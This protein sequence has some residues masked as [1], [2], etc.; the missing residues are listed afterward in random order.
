[1]VRF[2]INHSVHRSSQ[3]ALVTIH[4]TFTS[5]AKLIGITKLENHQ[6]HLNKSWALTSDKQKSPPSIKYN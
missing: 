1:M 3:E 2:Y 4:P 5:Y 6:I